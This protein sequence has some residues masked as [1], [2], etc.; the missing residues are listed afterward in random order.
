MYDFTRSTWTQEDTDR[1]RE[2]FARMDRE[3]ILRTMEAAA[4]MCSP[5]GYWG[6]GPRQSYVIQ[7]ELVRLEICRREAALEFALR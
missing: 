6:K 5:Q 4:H 2:R 1:A 3:K 7:R